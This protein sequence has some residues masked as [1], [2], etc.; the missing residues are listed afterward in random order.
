M[1][2]QQKRRP[3]PGREP[4]EVEKKPLTPE[5]LE[6]LQRKAQGAPLDPLLFGT[7]ESE[8]E[9]YE[10]EA[11]MDRLFGKGVRPLGPTRRTPGEVGP[12]EPNVQ[13]RQ[14]LPKV[15]QS[16]PEQLAKS[17]P[18]K[19]VRV[20]PEDLLRQNDRLPLTPEELLKLTLALA[21][22][23]DGPYVVGPYPL[24]MAG[25]VVREEHYL[26]WLVN[27][28]IR[29]WMRLQELQQGGMRRGEWLLFYDGR[30]LQALQDRPQDRETI[31]R[32]H[33]NLDEQGVGRHQQAAAELNRD[34][35]HFVA[36]GMSIE[37]ARH[38]TE[39]VHKEVLGLLVQGTFQAFSTTAGMMSAEGALKDLG[40]EAG[41][42]I[43]N[44]AGAAPRAEPRQ[45]EFARLLKDIPQLERMPPTKDNFDGMRRLQDVI[46]DEHLP[47]EVRREFLGEL[48]GRLGQEEV[49]TEKLFQVMKDV[50]QKQ[51]E[52][53]L[54][55]GMKVPSVEYVQRE[56]GGLKRVISLRAC[57][58]MFTEAFYQRA[59]RADTTLP[60][61]FAKLS[62][63]E[64]PKV[65]KL[66]KSGQLPFDPKTDLRPDALVKGK[67]P[68]TSGWFFASSDA[69]TESPESIRTQLAVGPDY[70]DGYVVVELPGH[71]VQP[72]ADGHGGAS[73]PTAL[74]LTIAPEGKLNE[75]PHEP[76][77]RTDPQAPGQRPVREVVLPPL[78]LS[79]MSS[80]TFVRGK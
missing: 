38:E 76:F 70:A 32:Q 66:I 52:K 64:A 53:Y 75:N 40:H 3:A 25:F 11:M 18:V 60:R 54:R 42:V 62:W 29:C 65:V 13:A 7:P 10:S 16:E 79:S 72:M 6:E 77:G 22:R 23:P 17:Y 44:K 63:K 12:T 80:V 49:T 45:H 48:R 39:R 2:V 34:V 33:P 74:D 36:E 21:T 58:N 24:R 14:V 57:W 15:R 61:Q 30:E 28:E 19:E 68:G 1:E 41:Q 37:R 20:F 27:G 35:E 67:D 5:E 31:H 59:Q 56:F 51:P 71:L 8:T 9:P 50:A 69:S 43:A 26:V 78:P 55:Q 47:A 73:R 46:Y 4:S